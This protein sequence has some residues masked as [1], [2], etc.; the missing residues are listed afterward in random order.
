VQ[1]LELLKKSFAKNSLNL[2]LI[3]WFHI[4]EKKSGFPA[5]GPP[6]MRKDQTLRV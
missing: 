5:G 6:D 1:K 4:I 2:A 3:K